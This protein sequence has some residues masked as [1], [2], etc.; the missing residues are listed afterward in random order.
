MTTAQEIGRRCAQAREAAGL[1]QQTLADAI[2]VSRQQVNR[3]E[4]GHVKKPDLILVERIAKALGISSNRLIGLKH[5][6]KTWTGN[7]SE[8]HTQLQALLDEK[9]K[10]AAATSIVIDVFYEH[11][12]NHTEPTD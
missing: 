4:R 10:L 5:P 11:L 1:T 6:P 3:I 2:G 7:D 12:K 9:G 8:I